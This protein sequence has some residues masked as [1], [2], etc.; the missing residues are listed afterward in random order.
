M[1]CMGVRCLTWNS[2]CKYR[3]IVFCRSR[4][5]FTIEWPKF[6]HLDRWYD[7]RRLHSAVATKSRSIQ[8]LLLRAPVTRCASNLTVKDDETSWPDI[9]RRLIEFLQS[10][11][12]LDLLG[13]QFLVENILH[14]FTER[15]QLI[16]RHRFPLRLSNHSS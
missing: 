4:W 9:A 10:T 16:D 12:E 13:L 1:F 14:Q 7:Q 5:I 8:Q 11:L 15:K 3:S 6:R 2:L